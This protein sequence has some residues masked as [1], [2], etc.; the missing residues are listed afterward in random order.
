MDGLVVAQNVAC[1]HVLGQRLGLMGCSD[2]EHARCSMVLSMLVQDLLEAFTATLWAPVRQAHAWD[3]GPNALIEA[4][5]LLMEQ[6]L[7]AL[8]RLYAQT[9][10]PFLLVGAPSVPDY[11]A[12]YLACILREAYVWSTG[13]PP[14]DDLYKTMLERPAIARHVRSVAPPRGRYTN[15]PAEDQVLKM[16]ATRAL[17]VGD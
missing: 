8:E 3:A 12:L 2:A 4:H 7:H 13:P 14:L 17:R 15:S 16:L 9:A 1:A 10:G 5:C 11:Y 6:R